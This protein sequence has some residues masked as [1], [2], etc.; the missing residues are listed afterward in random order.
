MLEASLVVPKELVKELKFSSNDVLNGE[1]ARMRLRNL[2][3][4]KAQA[5][6]NLYKHKVKLYFKTSEEQLMA[7]ETTIWSADDDFISIK[8]AT[9]PTKSVWAIEL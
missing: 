4:N 3:L 9:I 8:G 6:G 1:P 2:Y 7:V 5:M